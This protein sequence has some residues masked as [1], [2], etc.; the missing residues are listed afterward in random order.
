MDKPNPDID[1]RLA[2]H[3]VSLYYPQAVQTAAAEDNNNQALSQEFLREYIQYARSVSAPE[4]TTEA[5][6][7]LIQ[8][9]LAMRS[10]G[11]SSASGGS[12]SK[13]ISATPRQLE[14]LIRLSQA[15]A[16]MRLAVDVATSDVY[17]AIRL[18]RVATQTAATDPRTGT[19]DMDMISTGRTSLDRDAVAK[20]TE[21]LLKLFEARKGHRLSL[22][23]IRATLEKE[24]NAMNS[25]AFPV[26]MEDVEEALREIPDHIASFVERTKMVVVK[27]E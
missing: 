11:N 15:L 10:M 26:T 17:E 27:G 18:M 12:G 6:E 23:V 13:T 21:E 9:Y 24:M 16:K 2:K 1:R 4:L 25:N 7:I 20:I 5:A 8:G 22:Q 14:S 3:L 19:I